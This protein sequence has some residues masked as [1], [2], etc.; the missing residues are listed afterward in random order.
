MLPTV[1]MLLAAGG[2][3]AA[4]AEFEA[5]EGVAKSRLGDWSPALN[6]EFGIHA[7]ELKATGDTTFGARDRGTNTVSTLF[8][9]IEAAVAS[10][11][12]AFVPGS[13]R[14]V[15][16]GGG[17]IPLRE[18]GATI[19]SSQRIEGAEFGTDIST[20][21]KDMWHAAVDLR[22]RL[23]IPG[24]TI[25]I[26]PG[27]EYLQSR[28]RLEPAFT[29]RPQPTPG[30][31]NPPTLDFKSRSDSDVHRFV[32]PT[33]AVEGNVLQVGPVEIDVFLQGRV[34]FLIGDR[35]TLVVQ[36]GLL[37]NQQETAT[38]RMESNF[39]AGQVGFGIRGSF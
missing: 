38:S 28:F 33:L 25:L 5:E 6:V 1:L 22:F 3:R 10:P 17:S 31:E 36:T 20:S 19:I 34:Y 18:T 13:P 26:R 9:R 14:L 30:N 7:Q 35:D 27:F 12:L 24:Q 11:P 21:F 16:R 4:E 37:A 32:G 8:A 2:A 29:F 39:I 23:P 15:L